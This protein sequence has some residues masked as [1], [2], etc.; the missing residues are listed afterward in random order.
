MVSKKEPR[1][2]I[3]PSAYYGSEL[4]RYREARELSQ[5]QLGAMVYCSAGYIGQ[6][7]GATRNP[8]KEFSDRFD[9]V[10]ESDGHFARIYSLVAGNRHAPYFG[11]VAELEAQA[12]TI[13]L[14]APTLVPGLLQTP[15]Y[16]RAVIRTGQPFSSPAEK[17]EK[18][19]ARLGRAFDLSDPAAPEL[20]VILHESVLRTPVGG[21]RVMA[22]QLHH[23]L[24]AT[25]TGKLLLQVMPF[26]AGAHPLAAGSL[27]LMTFEDAP[28]LAYTEGMYAGQLLDEPTLVDLCQRAY[29][30]ARAAALPSEVSQE[31]IESVAEEYAHE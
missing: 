14:Y 30:L 9:K 19:R 15:D 24:K 31:L 26:S 25:R 27:F 17:E 28:P 1:P 7:E 11:Q 2:Y 20:W 21:P 10:F 16:A 3:S 18:L 22:E 12:K 6:F 23:L 29:N 4:R 5:E 8:Q 13:A